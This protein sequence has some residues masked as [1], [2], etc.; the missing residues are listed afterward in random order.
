MS[1][2]DSFESSQIVE[3]AIWN[4]LSALFYSAYAVILNTVAED[5]ATFDYGLY[6]GFVGLINVIWMIPAMIFLHIWQIQPFIM[7]TMT[8]FCAQLGFGLL[9]SLCYEYC[10]A[11]CATLLGPISSTVGFTAVMLPVC[12]V[13]DFLIWPD[14]EAQIG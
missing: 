11:K 7:P 1:Y 9:C 13:I 3:G 4:L 10:W 6:L 8:E 2:C 12:M 5:E 14:P